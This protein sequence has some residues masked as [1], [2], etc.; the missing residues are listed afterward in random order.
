MGLGLDSAILNVE[1]PL[2]N[3][4]IDASSVL[5]GRDKNS[6]IF[7]QKYRD[8]KVVISE[9]LPVKVDTFEKQIYS[10]DEI[11]GKDK[12]YNI[13]LTGDSDSVLKVIEEYIERKISALD[14]VNKHMIP[15]II[16][17][18]AKYDKK[19]YFLPQLMLSAE[20]MKK[21]FIRLEPL[22]R[23]ASDTIKGKII[24]ATVKGD[25]HDI[26]KNIVGIMF[27]NHGFKVIDLGKDVDS[28]VVIDRAVAENASLIG[29]SALMTTTMEEMMKFRELAE[30]NKLNIP[31]MVGGAVVTDDF[32]KS[33]GAYYAK[34]AVRAVETAKKILNI[35]GK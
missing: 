24:L 35:D 20:T 25:V 14:I 29:L 32:A 22:L 34:D 23:E 12:L 21:G 4:T 18:G 3:S 28:M 7:I 6:N 10:K 17:V 16:E 19:E 5:N 8:I 9:A 15:A 11:A 31:L 30:L 27:S 1:N 33:I 26:G 2:I 13:I